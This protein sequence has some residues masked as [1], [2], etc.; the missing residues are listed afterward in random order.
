MAFILEQIFIWLTFLILLCTNYLL[1]SFKY[2]HKFEFVA[3]LIG[4]VCI[5]A[6]FLWGTSSREPINISSVFASLN[7]NIWITLCIGLYAFFIC[8][9]LLKVIKR[10]NEQRYFYI[11]STIIICLLILNIGNN[12]V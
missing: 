10:K 6:I 8:F 5:I 11:F 2:M 9:I 4:Y 7:I 3:V 1:F 12:I